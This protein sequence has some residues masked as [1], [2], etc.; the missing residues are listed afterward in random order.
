MGQPVRAGRRRDSVEVAAVLGVGRVDDTG[1]PQPRVGVRDVEVADGH[2]ALVVGAEGAAQLLVKRFPDP[3]APEVQQIRK[4][5]IEGYNAER[6]TSSDAAGLAYVGSAAYA[7]GVVRDAN[8]A[9]QES[10]AADPQRVETQLEWAQLFLDKYDAGH[11]E[12]CVQDALRVNPEHPVA[13]TLY[14]RIRLE[15]SYAFVEAARDL[16]RALA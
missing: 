11:A 13:H 1:E 16:E 15:Q 10:V 6:I 8:T 2:R 12:E 9:F 3:T 4:E 5:F 7:L 14:A